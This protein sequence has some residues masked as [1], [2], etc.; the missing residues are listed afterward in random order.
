M[1]L[2]DGLSIIETARRSSLSRNTTK[3]WLREPVR[4]EMQYA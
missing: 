2:R 4:R 1:R 3:T